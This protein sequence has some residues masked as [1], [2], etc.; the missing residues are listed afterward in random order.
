[1]SDQA[2]AG[3]DWKLSAARL[4]YSMRDALLRSCSSAGTSRSMPL[5]GI[6]PYRSVLVILHVILVLAGSGFSDGPSTS[7]SEHPHQKAEAQQLERSAWIVT[8]KV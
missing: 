7:D 3:F 6:F 5:T 4:R 8:G 2:A 1:M